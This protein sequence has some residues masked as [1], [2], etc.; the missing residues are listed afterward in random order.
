MKAYVILWIV[1]ATFE[2]FQTALLFWYVYLE[3]DSDQAIDFELDMQRIQVAQNIVICVN[4]ALSIWLD[5]M[6]LSAYLRL[7]KQLSTRVTKMI[8]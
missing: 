5:L 2:L 1:L 4:E 3:N 8:A 6:I 7:S